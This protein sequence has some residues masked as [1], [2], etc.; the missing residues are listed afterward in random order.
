M[1]LMEMN[2]RL[3]ENVDFHMDDTLLMAHASFTFEAE[4]M[5][6]TMVTIRKLQVKKWVYTETEGYSYLSNES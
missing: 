2:V 3:W 6:S 5:F 1:D 4:P